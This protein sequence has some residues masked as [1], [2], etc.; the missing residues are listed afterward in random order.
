VLRNLRYEAVSRNGYVNLRC[1]NRPGCPS[2]I[3]QA[4]PTTIDDDYQYVIDQLPEVLGYLLNID[5]S[6]VPSDIAHQCCAQF[7]VT[8]ERIQ[9]RPKSDY[10]RILGWIATTDL[11]DNY[12]IGWLVE[13]LWH[14]IFGMPAV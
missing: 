7:A 12:G 13:K 9:E 11:T 5:P 3:F 8:R 10:I 2:T 4:F 1:T 6:E 14:I